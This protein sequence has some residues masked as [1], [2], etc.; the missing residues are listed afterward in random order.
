MASKQIIEVHTPLC[1]GCRIC[2]M[3]CSLNSGGTVNLEKANIRV[4][5]N[6]PESLY[7]PHICQL[8]DDPDCVNACPSDALTQDEQTGIISISD[9]LCTGCEACCDACPH[10]A[11]RWS[12]VTQKLYVCDRCGGD[13]LCVQFCTIKALQIK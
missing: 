6:Y 11:I 9:E 8:C 4:T 1:T 5:D 7:V 2:E 13:P 3:V 10:D 12:D